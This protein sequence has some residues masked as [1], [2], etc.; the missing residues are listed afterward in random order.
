M[1]R[2]DAFLVCPGVLRAPAPQAR[3]CPSEVA[4]V[5]HA[6]ASDGIA[7]MVCDSL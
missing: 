5:Q 6:R 2:W 1:L 4:P 3:C 7:A